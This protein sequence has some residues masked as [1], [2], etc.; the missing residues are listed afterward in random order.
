MIDC[1][2]IFHLILAKNQHK[3]PNCRAHVFLSTVNNNENYNSSSYIY[4]KQFPNDSLI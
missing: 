4:Y 3:K 1:G 2:K